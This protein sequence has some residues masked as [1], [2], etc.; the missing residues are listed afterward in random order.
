MSQGC[1]VNRDSTFDV[2]KKTVYSAELVARKLKVREQQH[3][4]TDRGGQSVGRPSSG[5]A[6]RHLY[7][8][9]QMFKPY[10]WSSRRI[11]NNL[12]CSGLAGNL[13]RVIY[14]DAEHS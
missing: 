2:Q 12:E 8:C 7:M 3:M 6:W 9:H 14:R 13:N 4:G 10:H 11:W 1:D 5:E